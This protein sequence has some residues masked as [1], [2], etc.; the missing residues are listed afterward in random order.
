MLHWLWLSFGLAMWPT[1]THLLTI[2]KWSKM[3]L[4]QKIQILLRCNHYCCHDNTHRQ[5]IWV[6]LKMALSLMKYLSSFPYGKVSI[7]N[8]SSE[9]RLIILWL[10][11]I[12]S[13][14]LPNALNEVCFL[15]GVCM[16]KTFCKKMN[17][18]WWNKLL[19]VMIPSIEAGKQD[20]H[21]KRVP[22]LAAAVNNAAL[23]LV[24][25]F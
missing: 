3:S 21:Q 7:F 11:I 20:G 18:N 24:Y 23:V 22:Y 14:R 6:P 2:H 16:D 15:Q 25:N 12:S 19:R 10:Q 9:P 8:T 17:N 5:Y 13:I 4:Q 1:V